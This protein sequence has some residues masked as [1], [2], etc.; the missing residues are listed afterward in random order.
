VVKCALTGGIATGKSYCLSKFAGLRLPVVDAD[1]LAREVVEPGTA[2]LA[3]IAAR[4]GASALQSDGRL[5]RKA[6]ADVVF[7]DEQARRDLEAII[8]PAVY[9][10]IRDWFADLQRKGDAL[11]IADIPLLFETDRADDFDVV[12]VVACEPARQFERL[13]A[14]GLSPEAARRRLAAQLSIDLKRARA[15]YVIDTS[16][17]RSDTDR[18]VTEIAATLRGLPRP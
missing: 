5:D 7:A 1:V 2:P 17:L 16:G 14:R 9:Q 6:L 3:A 13:T 4:F 11:G 18:Q 15:D 10:R 8:H 12:I